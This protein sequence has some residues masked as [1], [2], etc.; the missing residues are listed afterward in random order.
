MWVW[1][2]CV[3]G[4]V[5]VGVVGGC[6]A[7]SPGASLS[8]ELQSCLSS[9]EAQ[10]L[11]SLIDLTEGD[12][13]SVLTRRGAPLPHHSLL[14]VVPSYARLRRQGGCCTP[15]AGRGVSWDAWEVG[16]GTVQA[17]VSRRSRRLDIV[18]ALPQ[19]HVARHAG[20]TLA[21]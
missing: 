8:N 9:T 7:R 6:L 15:W 1:C 2:A 5:W 10:N 19:T 18:R 21:S 13:S 17:R 12:L 3:C 20:L 11:A 4:W 14:L 16:Q